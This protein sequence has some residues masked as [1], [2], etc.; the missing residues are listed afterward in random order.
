MSIDT[1]ALFLRTDE[2][3]ETEHSGPKIQREERKHD[4]VET[5]RHNCEVVENTPDRRVNR[6]YSGIMKKKPTFG[7]EF[8]SGP[9]VE[10]VSDLHWRKELSPPSSP[11]IN[12]HALLNLPF[13]FIETSSDDVSINRQIRF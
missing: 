7:V 9:K 6:L 12:S 13:G 10:L 11:T 4:V 5:E 2:L 3:H 8:E 1:P